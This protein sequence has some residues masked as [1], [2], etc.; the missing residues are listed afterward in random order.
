VREAEFAFSHHVV[1][2]GNLVARCRIEHSPRLSNLMIEVCGQTFVTAPNVVQM[3]NA[4]G[5]SNG[6]KAQGQ[7]EQFDF[8]C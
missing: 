1:L 7:P 3:S 2:F 5:T 6:R 8:L 4:E